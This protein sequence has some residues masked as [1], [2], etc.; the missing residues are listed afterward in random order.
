MRGTSG[1]SIHLKMEQMVRK[2]PQATIQTAYDSCAY[3]TVE[4]DT[5]ALM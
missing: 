4:N 5:S 3:L 2:N 1:K